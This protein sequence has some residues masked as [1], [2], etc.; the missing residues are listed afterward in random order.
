MPTISA[1]RFDYD[2]L[3]AKLKPTDKIAIVSCNSCA[4]RCND[5]GGEIGLENLARKLE[6]DGYSLVRRELLHI[7]CDPKHL[8]SRLEDADAA[9]ALGEANVVLPLACEAGHRTISQLLPKADVI[10]IAKTLGK[11]THTP[12]TGARLTNPRPELGLDVPTPDGLPLA[13]AVNQLGLHSGSF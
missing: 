4:R 5:L 10:D 3:T 2:G 1:R 8:A 7:A 9:Q 13:D 6:T 12:A 11:G